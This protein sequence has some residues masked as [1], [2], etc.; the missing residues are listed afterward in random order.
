LA[1]GISE[2][3][4]GGF[5]YAN[6]ILASDSSLFKRYSGNVDQFKKAGLLPKHTAALGDDMWYDY[7][8]RADKLQ[9]VG[10][11]HLANLPSW[12]DRLMRFNAALGSAPNPVTGKGFQGDM[13]VVLVPANKVSNPDEYLNSLK[14][15]WTSLGKWSISKNGIILVIGAS[16]D[17]RTVAWS[18]ATTGMPFGNGTMIQALNTRLY[19]LNLDPNTLFGNVPATARQVGDKHK[20][21]YNL[22][23][24]GAVGNIV[25]QKYPFIRACMQCKSKG[26]T[27]VGYVNL[28]DLVP[29]STWGKIVMFIIV[30][31]LSLV[32]WGVMLWTDLFGSI[33]GNT[34]ASSK[35]SSNPFGY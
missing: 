21:D 22:S 25:L 2:P 18:R 32:L 1:N 14:A 20:V 23:L 5:K 28:K 16:N 11:L 10:G 33:F 12:E 31:F 29:I 35:Q 26:D 17:G 13:H 19:G 27:G 15:Y 9:V 34:F 3:V 6:Y 8:M 24:S 7:G 30:F 4:T